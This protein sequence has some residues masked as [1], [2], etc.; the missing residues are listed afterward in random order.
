M[1]NLNFKNKPEISECFGDAVVLVVDAWASV[2]QGSIFFQSQASLS[3]CCSHQYFLFFSLFFPLHVS[4]TFSIVT[5]EIKGTVQNVWLL[6]YLYTMAIDIT[7]QPSSWNKPS[8][9]YNHFSYVCIA[10]PLESSAF[11][12]HPQ[13]C[14]VRPALFTTHISRSSNAGFESWNNAR[15]SWTPNQSRI[16]Y[17]YV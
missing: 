6:N 11:H 8:Y 12:S 9:L 3:L 14:N 1:K 16:C 5:H 13:C 17:L 4:K 10:V 15:L 2:P 7:K